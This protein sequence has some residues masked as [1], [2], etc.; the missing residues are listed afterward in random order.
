MVTTEESQTLVNGFKQEP[1]LNGGGSAAIAEACFQKRWAV[2]MAKQ[3]F[4]RVDNLKGMK[5]SFIC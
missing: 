4:R 5:S 1:A 3:E 2:S